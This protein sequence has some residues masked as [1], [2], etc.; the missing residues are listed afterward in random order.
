M[1]KKTLFKLVITLALCLSIFASN[2]SIAKASTNDK[3]MEE[4]KEYLL[5]IGTPT[6]ILD[7]YTNIEPLR[8]LYN[9]LYTSKGTI[10]YSGAVIVLDNGQK[11]NDRLGI[12]PYNIITVLEVKSTVQ[13]D[14]IGE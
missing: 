11:I 3:T 4:M 13:K 5:N 14:Y 1:K 8:M 7:T 2:L 12:S 9:K 10:S 6:Y